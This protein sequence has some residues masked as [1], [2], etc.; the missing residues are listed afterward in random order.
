MR[1][2]LVIGVLWSSGWIPW[3]W[4][5]NSYFDIVV[6]LMDKTVRW[7]FSVCKIEYTNCIQSRETQ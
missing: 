6:S 4:F 2:C 1:N 3:R 5:G 7:Q